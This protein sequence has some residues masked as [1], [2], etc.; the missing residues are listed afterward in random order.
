[1]HILPSLK[2]FRLFLIALLAVALTGGIAF[3]NSSPA[4]AT[5]S[6]PSVSMEV[7]A[8]QSGLGT[9]AEDSPVY[10]T[11]QGLRKGSPFTFDLFS[12]NCEHVNGSSSLKISNRTANVSLRLP[13]FS[14]ASGCSISATLIAEFDPALWPA[15]D[16]THVIMATVR[17]VM[18]TTADGKVQASST[19]SGV[20]CEPVYLDSDWPEVDMGSIRAL[21]RAIRTFG[22]VYTS[23]YKT[24]YL[25][26]GIAPDSDETPCNNVNNNYD[27]ECGT[28][29][30]GF[31]VSSERCGGFNNSTTWVPVD[32][33]ANRAEEAKL[34][35]KIDQVAS[36][37]PKINASFIALFITYL[38]NGK[39]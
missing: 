3:F 24:G 22:D 29:T 36:K 32:V 8:A 38:V 18:E 35:T 31:P 20:V 30:G 12:L 2:T 23:T 27:R 7:F 13:D 37:K 21:Q 34:N 17:T 5:V 39:V 33:A 16:A 15:C 28:D 19:T 11:G 9:F 14:S 26:C 6:P 25:T 4:A 1:M 10:L